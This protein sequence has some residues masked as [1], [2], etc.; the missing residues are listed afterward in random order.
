[1][2]RNKLGIAVDLTK[3]E[4]KKIFLD[5]VRHADAVIENYSAE[6]LP[7]LGLT[8]DVLSEVNPKLLMLSMPAF[9]LGNAWSN[10]RAYGGTLEQ[11]SGLPLYTGHP[12]GPPAMTSYAYGDPNGGLNAAAAMMLGLYLQRTTGKG[13][14][15]NMSQVEGML[16]L[17]AAFMIEQ[18]ALGTDPQRM[19]NRHAMYAPHGCY[20]CRTHDTWV[21]ISISDDVHWDSLCK[22]IGRKDWLVNLNFGSSLQRL[23]NQSEIDAAVS[24]WTEQ[25][26][27]KEVVAILQKVDIAAG[28]VFTLSQ[29]LDD[30]HL[31]ERGFWQSIPREY[32]GQYLSSSTYFRTN[33]K[34]MPINRPAPTLGQHTNMVLENILSMSKDKIQALEINGV[35]GTEARPKN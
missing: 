11:A 17:T 22:L 20:P 34:P 24:A 25:L 28:P 12:D 16:T 27:A 9:G 31:H 21:V 15:I 5:L 3:P 29:V 8:Y 35:I 19:G 18:S 32:V 2:N 26:D 6:V 1:M 4:G 30:P 7:K 33:G 23:L 10:T 14:H 13:R